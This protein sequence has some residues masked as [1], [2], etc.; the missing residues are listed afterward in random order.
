MGRI[1]FYSVELM[2]IAHVHEAYGAINI[3]IHFWLFISL[4]VMHEVL[5]YKA[6]VIQKRVL[7][8][9]LVRLLI[10]DDIFLG[11]IV[12]IGFYTPFIESYVQH[13]DHKYNL[14]IQIIITSLMAGSFIIQ[15]VTY[16]K[17]RSVHKRPVT[18]KDTNKKTDQS[19]AP[20][21]PVD[22]TIKCSTPKTTEFS[23]KKTLPEKINLILKVITH[24]FF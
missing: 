17:L 7:R 8:T 2:H 15:K 3:Q 24:L 4:A 14:I 11:L 23:S 9:Y 20:T 21:N 22:S 16:T 19:A 10:F 6:D 18:S 12:I 1:P 13:T 5:H